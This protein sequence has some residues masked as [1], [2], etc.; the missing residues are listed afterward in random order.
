MSSPQKKGQSPPA[1]PHCSSQGQTP[2]PHPNLNPNPAP[3]SPS[4]APAKPVAPT[5]PSNSDPPQ[6]SKHGRQTST[7]SAQSGGQTGNLPTSPKISFGPTGS[8]V[9]KLPDQGPPTTPGVGLNLE[10][11]RC[12]VQVPLL[13]GSKANPKL[14]EKQPY[15]T[16]WRPWPLTTTAPQYA[17]LRYWCHRYALDTYDVMS[18]V[19]FTLHSDSSLI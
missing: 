4:L 14:Q 2:I 6:G 11:T 15:V 10:G 16:A 1:A 12:L 5:T 7:T 19:G 13:P 3:V 8:T 18:G 9:T 17:D